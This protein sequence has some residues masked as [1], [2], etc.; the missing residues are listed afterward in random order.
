MSD[1]PLLK[2]VQEVE[3]IVSDRCVYPWL[4]NPLKIIEYDKIVNALKKFQDEIKRDTVNIKYEDFG[5]AYI[6]IDDLNEIIKEVFGVLDSH[7]KLKD[8][9]MI[10]TKRICIIKGS[11]SP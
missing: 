7:D 8:G 3:I 2:N 4:R 5:D 10:G 6:F 11:D 9:D 1:V